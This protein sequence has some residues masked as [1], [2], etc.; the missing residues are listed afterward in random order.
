MVLILHVYHG[1]S[2]KRCPQDVSLD[3][4]YFVDSALV[5]FCWGTLAKPQKLRIKEF[6]ILSKQRKYGCPIF[7]SSIQK[8]GKADRTCLI[9]CNW[10]NTFIF[11][12]ETLC[13]KILV[14]VSYIYFV[15]SSLCVYHVEFHLN[16]WLQSQLQW[17]YN[18]I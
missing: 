2:I 6:F 7:Q 11:T 10:S 15:G 9:W 1:W 12:I 5:L 18:Y 17:C 8:E 4:A 16:I 13:G 3:H 14:D